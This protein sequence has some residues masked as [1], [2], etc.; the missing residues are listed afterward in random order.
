RLT[1]LLLDPTMVWIGER[2]GN[3]NEV[4]PDVDAHVVNEESG[5]VV[6]ADQIE[7]SDHVIQDEGDDIVRIGDKELF[8]QSTQNVEVGVVAAATVPFVT[9]F[10]SL[11]TE[12]EGGRPTDSIFGIDLRTRHLA[13]RFVI[14]SDSSHDSNANAADDEVSSVVKSLILNPPI[15][16]TV[17][18]TTVAANI[19]ST[20]VPRAGD[21]LVRAS[22]FTDS[23]FVGTVGPDVAGSSQHVGTELSAD[24]FYV[25]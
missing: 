16:T 14:S 12:G 22:I 23:A 8:K 2:E 17:V 19:S 5:D 3:Q 1:C 6:V 11:T 18:A 10:A 13:E 25:S 15:M 20:L 7:E 4:V 24:S 9:S 21:K